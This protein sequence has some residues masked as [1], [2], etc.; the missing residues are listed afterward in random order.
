MQHLAARP[1]LATTLLAAGLAACAKS[2]ENLPAGPTPEQIACENESLQGLYP[3]LS[4]T[5]LYTN[6]AAHELSLEARAYKPG[7]QLWSDGAEKTRFIALPAGTKIDTADMSQW[8][9]PVGT[10]VWKEFRLGAKR[11]ETRFYFKESDI[12]WRRTTYR[13]NA[14]ETEAVRLDAGELN[15]NGTTYEVPETTKC[16]SCH[17]GAKDELLG[18]EA[19]SLALP[20]A[21]GLTLKTLVD[22]G[23]LTHP[24]AKT[25]IALPE[26]GHGSG[27]ALGF[28]HANCGVSCHSGFSFSP[29]SYVDL[30]LRLDGNALLGSAPAPAVSEMAP[31]K[32]TVGVA[33]HVAPGDLP[34]TRITRGNADQSA[35]VTLVARRTTTGDGQMP[36]LATHVVDAE[37]VAA[38]RAW[39]GAL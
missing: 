28:L 11:I 6:I 39:I 19:V 1:L 5:G 36:P 2:A 24:P 4:C 17:D 29:L 16:N 12:K 21:E 18:F 26:D 13:W 34:T 30:S 37:G 8:I 20:T 31:W 9:F 35:V 33:M 7:T 25:S 3:R 10:R 32:S 23:W 14:D 27:P 15:V 38:L 22:E